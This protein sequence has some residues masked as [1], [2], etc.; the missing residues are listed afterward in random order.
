MIA[1]RLLYFRRHD[2]C[3][4]PFISLRLCRLYFSYLATLGD[5]CAA[6]V[7]LRLARESPG[8]KVTVENLPCGQEYFRRSDLPEPLS[9]P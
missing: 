2:S 3:C 7:R 8:L 4:N 5:Y 9:L 6:K 1:A